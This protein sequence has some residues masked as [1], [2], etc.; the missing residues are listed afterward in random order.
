MSI[1]AVKRVPLTQKLCY[2]SWCSIMQHTFSGQDQVVSM[3][4]WMLSGALVSAATGY[5]ALSASRY[6]LFLAV[7]S[8]AQMLLTA[9]LT[10][11]TANP[12]SNPATSQSCFCCLLLALS[13]DRQKDAWLHNCLFVAILMFGLT[14][15]NLLTSGRKCGNGH[16]GFCS[17]SKTFP[18]WCLG[19]H[20]RAK[21]EQLGNSGTNFRQWSQ[22]LNRIN[23]VL[24][25]STMI[26]SK[27]CQLAVSTL[28]TTTATQRLILWI[29]SAL[30]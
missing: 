12:G 22:L 9:Q 30:L 21:I 23:L 10:R 27:T 18:Y 24:H 3:H 7:A 29:D 8:K 4:V 11:S 13:A 15:D 19:G 17:W 5:L 25:V 16:Q 6:F 28:L 14:L 26:G 20:R 2:W 1:D